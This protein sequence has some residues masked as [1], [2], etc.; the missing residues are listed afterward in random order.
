MR[1]FSLHTRLTLQTLALGMARSLA[2]GDGKAREAARSRD[3]ETRLRAMRQAHHRELER[4][5]ES[6]KEEVEAAER[7]AV[8]AMTAAV[9]LEKV[10]ADEEMAAAEAVQ[11]AMDAGKPSKANKP[12]KP[13]RKLFGDQGDQGDRGEQGDQVAGGGRLD[14][15]SG[16]RRH[17]GNARKPGATSCLSK[18]ATEQ[19]TYKV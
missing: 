18:A 12:N 6:A 17:R 16:R 7:R 5:R 3:M 4:V 9:E 10:A 11:Q 15:E 2:E 14:Q 1:V 19:T 13:N 8:E